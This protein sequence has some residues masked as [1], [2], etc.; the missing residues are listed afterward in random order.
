M[1]SN[2]SPLAFDSRSPGLLG[3]TVRTVALVLGASL[4]FVGA[5]CGGMLIASMA[6]GGKTT[7]DTDTAA[8]TTSASARANE[9]LRA[10]APPHRGEHLKKPGTSI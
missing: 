8:A 10:P 1:E 5:L 6:L 4:G 3:A 7:S 9:P 2:S